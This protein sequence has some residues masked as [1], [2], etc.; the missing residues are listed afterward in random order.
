M[1]YHYE[2]SYMDKRIIKTKRD[3][4]GAFFQ[5]RAKSSLDKIKISQLCD[6]AL[7]N[8]S[9]FYKYYSDIYDLSDAL[10]D[11]IVDAIIGNFDAIGSLYDDP[12]GFLDGL[13]DAVHQYETE[14]LALFNDRLSVLVNKIEAHLKQHY[15]SQGHSPRKDIEISFFIGGATHVMLNPQY[16]RELVRETMVGLI[17]L[18]NGSIKVASYHASLQQGHIL[19]T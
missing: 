1:D 10:E 2:E 11:E 19:L 6:L 18:R 4:R 8:K 15:D 17:A 5:L 12:Q 9:T 3:I 7:I 13:F 14:V 16:D